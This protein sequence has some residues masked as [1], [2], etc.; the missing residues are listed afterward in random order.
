MRQDR[1]IPGQQKQDVS[2]GKERFASLNSVATATGQAWLTSIPGAEIIAMECLPGSTLPARLSGM[3]YLVE[4]TGES[5]RILPHAIVEH[6][7][8]TAAGALVPVTEGSTGKV[9]MRITHAGIAT[10]FQIRI[11]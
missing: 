2:T 11:G 1:Y 6:L 9:T 7:T 4:R 8:T 10:V 3:G 5:Q